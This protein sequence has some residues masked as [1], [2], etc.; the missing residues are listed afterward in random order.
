MSLTPAHQATRTST[1]SA[2]VYLHERGYRVVR[3]S[4]RR[5]AFPVPF[6]LI[7]WRDPEHLLCIRIDRMAGRK[8]RFSVQEEL[9][10]LSGLVRNGYYP[11]ELQYWIRERNIWMMYRVMAGGWVLITEADHAIW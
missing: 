2:M 6:H 3:I 10:S 8:G 11:G 7:A 9:L 4:H 1:Y 5:D